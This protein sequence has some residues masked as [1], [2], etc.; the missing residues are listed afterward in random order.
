MSFVNN[1]RPYLYLFPLGK[2][3]WH[4]DIL[5]RQNTDDQAQE[6]AVEAP[7]LVQPQPEVIQKE[8]LAILDDNLE[9]DDPK[10]YA[11]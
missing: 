3:F 8:Q 2:G 11:E 1:K 4:L 6:I 5:L 7:L 9:V 10:S